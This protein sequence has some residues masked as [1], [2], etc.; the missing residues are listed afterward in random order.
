[1]NYYV[2]GKKIS[3]SQND[4]VAK[5]GEGQIFKKGDTAYKIYEDLAK[6]IPEAKIKELQVLNSPNI[7]GPK[8]IV[9][10]EKRQVVGF[11]MDWLGDDVIP[12]CK[13]F[14]NNFRQNNNI[15]NDL[16]IQLVE[17]MKHHIQF[18]HQ[19]RCLIVDG[20]E[21]NYLVK[22]D[23]LT[24]YFIDVNSWQTP[25]Y[26]ATAIMASIRDWS[27]QTFT[28]L[29]DWFS[30]AVVSFQLFIGIHP[31]KGKH[32]KY[33]KNDFENRIKNSVSVFNPQVSLPPTVRDFT[34]IP[35]A[36]KDWY[37]KMFENGARIGPPITPGDAQKMQVIVKLVKSTN[38][39]E[40]INILEVDGDILYHNPNM[41]VTK[42]PDKVYIGKTDYKVSSGVELL[43]TPLE[44]IPV[45]VKVEDNRPKFKVINSSYNI[46][47]LNIS[48]TEMMIV[49]G[50]LYLRYAGTLNEIDFVVKG[51]TVIPMIKMSWSISALSSQL[52]SNVIYQST[53]GKAYLYIP[54]PNVSGKSS[55]FVMPVP[56]LDKY[57]II[58]IR[59]MNQIC[60]VIG[61]DGRKYDRI[62]IIF[63]KSMNKYIC[64]IIEDVDYI[65]LN[66]VVLDNGVCINITEDNA[67]EI[68]L[69]RTDKPD[70]KRIE[71]P[72]IDNTMRL[73]KDGNIVKFFQGNKLYS[74]KMKK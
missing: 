62:I 32:P 56:D 58:D 1:M 3:L 38:S 21:L 7:I 71:D 11:T 43:F 26:G 57:K 31:F 49:D 53:L 15:E 72:D 69:N 34:L 68:F 14:T 51:Q 4:F 55:M 66:F 45:F 65:P 37:Y 20:N 54:C 64:R 8:S 35:S 60:M 50:V 33:K 39:F 48:A 10:N 28:E 24:P 36:Y 27:T 52:G 12:L 2:D 61:H 19:N 5:G 22:N 41:M 63:D 13:L 42:T 40:I 73:C 16:V 25:S 17:N 47:E 67:I 30:F 59:Y 46:K 74:M 6:M 23:F 44:Q 9:Q 70:V 18:I 29:T